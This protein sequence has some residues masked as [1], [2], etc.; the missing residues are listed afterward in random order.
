MESLTQFKT[1]YI[2]CDGKEF[3]SKEECQTHEKYIKERE[4]KENRK[5]EILSKLQV[6]DISNNDFIRDQTIDAFSFAY[7]AYKFIYH[8]DCSLMDVLS[9]YDND[10]NG[11][12]NFLYT[13]IDG[14]E[15]SVMLNVFPQLEVGETYLIIFYCDLGGDY[16]NIPVNTLV[17]LSDYK[18]YYIKQI[19]E[20]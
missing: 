3:S 8:S 11:K 14:V 18:D 2:A 1:I 4:E 17:K 7:K 13:I 6:I 15:K 10:S 20:L 5:L 12:P 9:I 16:P 19:N